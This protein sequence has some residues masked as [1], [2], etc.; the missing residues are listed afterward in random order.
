LS[1]RPLAERARQVVQFISRETG[2]QLP[3]IGVGGIFTADDARRMLDAGAA[4]L[5]I[6][7]GF[8]YVGPGL[9]RAINRELSTEEPKSRELR[10]ED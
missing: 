1:G 2:G 6:Y 7:T 9:T 10:T 5:Q 4:L 8:V 3:I